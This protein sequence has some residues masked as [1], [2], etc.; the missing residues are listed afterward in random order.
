MDKRTF[1][2]V[3]KSAVLLPGEIRIVEI[4]SERGP[5]TLAELIAALGPDFAA[6]ARPSW[7]G[8]N[9]DVWHWLAD[10]LPDYK[11]VVCDEWPDH[12]SAAALWRLH[13]EADR[14][15]LGYIDDEDEDEDFTPT[16]SREGES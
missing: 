12:R 5:C 8:G 1:T 10:H 2:E 7:P 3:R 14:R 9:S 16:E 13:P 4:L 6:A 11:L 15:I